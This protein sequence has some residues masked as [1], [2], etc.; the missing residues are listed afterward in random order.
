MTSE[1]LLTIIFSLFFII[2]GLIVIRDAGGRG[3]G[4]FF[5]CFGVIILIGGAIYSKIGNYN[6]HKIF[7]EYDVEYIG[8]GLYRKGSF[9]FYFESV[10]DSQVYTIKDSDDYNFNLHYDIINYLRKMDK[11]TLESI[12]SYLKSSSK[13][14]DGPITLTIIERN[15]KTELT[16]DI[17]N[18]E[19]RHKVV[20]IFEGDSEDPNPDYNHLYK[21]YELHLKE[22]NEGDE[23]FAKK[24]LKELF[25]IDPSEF[26][27]STVYNGI[28]KY[29]W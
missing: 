9:E 12:Y 28:T 13:E 6:F 11:D 27:K 25:D 22:Y 15:K 3:A 8:D 16:Y 17:I 2:G 29:K 1:L 23:S 5:L 7:K 18:H 4:I 21:D 24:L 20:K 14:N 10:G 26:K 19:F